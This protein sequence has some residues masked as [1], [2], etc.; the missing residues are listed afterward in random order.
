[1]RSVFIH[2]SDADEAQVESFL[3]E[4]Y[5]GQRKPWTHPSNTDEILYI[6]LYR[7]LRAEVDDS[8]FEAIV[9]T[10]GG[11]PTS[12]LVAHVSGRHDGT[13]EVYAFVTACL[14]RF[15][16]A[17]QDEYSNHCWTL[18]ELECHAQFQGHP[19]FD[20]RGWYESEHD[21]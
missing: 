4:S 12:S 7:E 8:E 14:T 13:A 17:A 19:F 2:L 15:T 20:F 9:T 1:M 21:N 6:D 5:P 11:E 18:P 10:L 3:D 16:G